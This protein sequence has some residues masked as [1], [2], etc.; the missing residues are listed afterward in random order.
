MLRAHGQFSASSG[1]DGRR[2]WVISGHFCDALTNP[3]LATRVETDGALTPA[4]LRR[5]NSMLGLLSVSISMVTNART[6]QYRR[7]YRE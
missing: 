4:I 5:Y 2:S 6:F 7:Q 3:V 1:L